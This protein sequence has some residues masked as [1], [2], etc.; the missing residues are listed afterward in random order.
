MLSVRIYLVITERQREICRGLLAPVLRLQVYCLARRTPRGGTLVVPSER[1]LPRRAAR[2]MPN[3]GTPPY[4]VAAG[5]EARRRQAER[6]VKHGVAIALSACGGVGQPGAAQITLAAICFAVAWMVG[7]SRATR[8]LIA[9]GDHGV[10]TLTA[11]TTWP[12]RDR[13]GT[14]IDCSALSSSSSL[15]AMPVRRT[16]GGSRARPRARLP[17]PPSHDVRAGTGVRCERVRRL[18]TIGRGRQWLPRWRQPAGERRPAIR[19]AGP[20]PVSGRCLSSCLSRSPSQ[21]T[22]R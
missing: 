19:P 5:V 21:V 20:W 15:M 2:C 22:S 12:V 11:A 10:A 16:C 13:T 8:S 14:A 1:D 18:A 17:P 3:D 6:A 9:T 7:P 4:V